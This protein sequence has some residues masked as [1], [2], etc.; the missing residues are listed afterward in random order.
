MSGTQEDLAS[1]LE[2]AGVR[3]RRRGAIDVAVTALRRA[4]QLS[5]P[6]HRPRRM[7]A[8]AELAYQRG[9]PD[10]AVPLLREME[11]IDLG[12]LELARA[13]SLRELMDATRWWIA[14]G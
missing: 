4:V 9:R 6:K 11:A 1:E 13:R 5:A 3:A 10:I 8:T 7:F 14:R 2:E 12:F